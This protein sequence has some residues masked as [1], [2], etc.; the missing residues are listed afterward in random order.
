METY[1]VNIYRRGEA[2]PDELVGMIRKAGSQEWQV[3]SNSDEL[4][5]FLAGTEKTKK[6]LQRYLTMLLARF[7]ANRKLPM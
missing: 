3:F 2:H 7:E 5:D 6:R 4:W 1:V